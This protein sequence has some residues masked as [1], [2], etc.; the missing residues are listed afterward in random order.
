MPALGVTAANDIASLALIWYVRGKTLSQT[1]YDKPFLKWL[2]AGSKNFSSGNKQISEP[3]QGLYM[4]DTPGFLQGFSG[5]DSINFNA[6]SNALRVVYN[7]YE[8]IAS[9]WITWTDL[10]IDGISI[11]DDSK[12]GRQSEHSEVTMTRLTGLL[13][14]RLDDFGESRM[15]ARS[16]MFWADGTQDPKQVPGV[17]SLITDTP[18]T[19]TA[20]GGLSSVSNVWWRSRANLALQAQPANSALIQFFN[21]ELVQLK[22]YGGR[23]NKWLAGSQFLDALR[24]EL[25][26]KGYFTLEG[27]MGSKATDL[28][29]GGIHISGIGKCEFEPTL[30]RKGQPKRSYIFDGRR[31][32]LRPME[33]ESS[34]VLTPERPYNYLVFL[35]NVKD[36]EALEVT[37]LNC[38]GVYAV[39]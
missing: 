16:D 15:R 4:S 11:I 8:T 39:V 2:M 34:K 14:N 29:M 1:T 38:H 10:L 23:P 33:G 5:D 3:I 12:G 25:F 9:L 22:V 30:D 19:A 24:S 31:L 32:R 18:A 36:T 13:E 17:I 28:G 26:A 21:S 7:W 35:H 6:A 27:F 37:Q 20:I